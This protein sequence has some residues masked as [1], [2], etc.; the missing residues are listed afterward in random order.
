M[1]NFMNLLGAKGRAASSPR[2]AG[3]AY[4]LTFSYGYPAVENLPSEA[5]AQAAS[6]VLR[7]RGELPLQYGGASG[8]PQF[9]ETLLDKLKRDQGINAKRENVLVTNGSMQVL[10]LLG[11]MFLDP[12][13]TVIIEA[14]TFLGAVRVLINGGANIVGVGLDDEGINAVELRTRLEALRSSGRTPKYIYI[15]PNFQNPA[16]IC[17]S[18]PRRMEVIALA[19]EFGTLI[20]ED[21]AYFDLRFEGKKLPTMYE[22]SGGRDVVYAGTFS[23]TLAPA[24]RL[25]WAVGEPELISRMSTIKV[26]GTGAF[27]TNIADEFCKDEGLEKNIAKLRANYAQRAEVMLD[28]LTEYMPPGVS[29][30]KP[31]GGFFVWLTFPASVDTEELVELT[32]KQG[33]DFLPGT[34]CF[35]DGSGRQNARMAF[36]YVPM[37]RI[38]EGIRVIAECT[39]QLLR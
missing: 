35:A 37:D 14:P 38:P 21:D 8:A 34:R 31:S 13:D 12:G 5:I 10:G 20:V 17:M 6:K 23:K 1:S 4:E 30:S 29:W 3:A 15:I 16:G 36:S 39:R 24:M 25:G 27:S 33:V 11:E 19:R 9:V 7:E 2:L 26:D 18:L 32:R 22:L 28:A